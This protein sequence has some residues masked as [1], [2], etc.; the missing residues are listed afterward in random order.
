[1]PHLVHRQHLEERLRWTSLLF[2]LSPVV[3]VYMRPPEAIDESRDRNLKAATE[4]TAERSLLK[5][6]N[7]SYKDTNTVLTSLSSSS[8]PIERQRGN[9]DVHHDTGLS[10][11]GKSRG[12]AVDHRRLKKALPAMGYG[13]DTDLHKT[14]RRKHFSSS[15]L[16]I[17]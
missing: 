17:L 8:S 13:F 6:I 2:K 5:I 12:R 15:R 4:R 9:V 7:G 11:V 1:M 10:A 3:T 16:H 14:L